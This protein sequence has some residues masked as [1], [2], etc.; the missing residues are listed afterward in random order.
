MTDQSPFDKS[1]VLGRLANDESLFV[2]LATFFLEDAPA[3][4]Q[5]AR[6]ALQVSNANQLL[7]AAHAIKGM[8]ANLSA[9]TTRQ[10]AQKLEQQAGEGQLD[11]AAE[12]VEQLDREI[13]RLVQA[14]EPHCR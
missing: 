14:L 1:A 8:A 12:T 5:R 9:E 10:C 11:D 4:M 3:A 7:H 2:D 6:Q 13:D